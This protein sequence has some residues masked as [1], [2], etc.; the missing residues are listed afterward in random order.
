MCERRGPEVCRQP[1]D[2]LADLDGA[3]SDGVVDQPV[4]QVASS[5]VVVDGVQC[6]QHEQP[7]TG[8]E[9]DQ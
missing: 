3:D 4:G 7:C 9:V 1:L 2:H 6:G 5:E 8:G